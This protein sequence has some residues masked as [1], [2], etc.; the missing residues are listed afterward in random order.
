[1]GP[2]GG[3][4]RLRGFEEVMWLGAVTRGSSLGWGL[5]SRD[6]WT[7]MAGSLGWW[8]RTSHCRAEAEA[9][10]GSFGAGA[11]SGRGR[12]LLGGGFPSRKLQ[13]E[14]S[15]LLGGPGL[16]AEGQTGLTGGGWGRAGLDAE[17]RVGAGEPSVAAGP[18]ERGRWAS[19]G[20]SGGGRPLGELEVPRVHGLW[21]SAASGLHPHHPRALGGPRWGRCSGGA[22]GGPVPGPGRVA[23]AGLPPRRPPPLPVRARAPLPPPPA[24]SRPPRC[25]GVRRGRKPRWGRCVSSL[26]TGLCALAG[27]GRPGRRRGPQGPRAGCRGGAA[28]GG[29]DGRPPAPPGPPGRHLGR[30]RSGRADQRQGTDLQGT[31]GLWHW[32]VWG[33]GRGLSGP[34]G[35]GG[36]EGASLRLGAGWGEAPMGGGSRFPCC[37]RSGH[38][39][40]PAT[41]D[42]VQGRSPR[43]WFV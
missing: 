8:A 39:Q 40:R 41:D 18:P 16:G 28:A 32:G 36:R 34:R 17:A 10:R 22:G 3:G 33:E 38:G 1:M 21:S 31:V 27:Q 7:I 2:A 23:E 42:V 13:S 5:G 9:L 14:R 11:R 19:F 29:G 43:G 26:L 30:G 6:D 24:S 20:G 15:R 35:S 25:R 4:L 12:G 37:E